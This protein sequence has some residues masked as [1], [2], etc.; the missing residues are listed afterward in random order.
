MV[1]VGCLFVLRRSAEL[2]ERFLKKILDL[3]GKKYGQ[4]GQ[5]GTHTRSVLRDSNLR[6]ETTP[7]LCFA[8]CEVRGKKFRARVPRES[9][10]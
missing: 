1:T 6:G 10:A 5:M 3:D 9:L 2:M 8:L 7:R 4:Y